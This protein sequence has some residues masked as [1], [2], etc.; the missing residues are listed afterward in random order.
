MANIQANLAGSVTLNTTNIEN[1]KQIEVTCSEL[2]SD[3]NAI[4]AETKAFSNAVSEIREL[5]ES[6]NG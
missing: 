3:F 1:C 5:V 6:N 4:E 2:A